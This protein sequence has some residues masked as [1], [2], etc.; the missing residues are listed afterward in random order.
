MV[1]IQSQETPRDGLTQAILL[2]MEAGMARRCSGIRFFPGP[3]FILLPF[4]LEEKSPPSCIRGS[5]R[6]GRIPTSASLLCILLPVRVQVGTLHLPRIAAAPV[7]T[8]A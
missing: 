4:K 2:R 5:E 3:T 7:L 1:K 8:S 6:G